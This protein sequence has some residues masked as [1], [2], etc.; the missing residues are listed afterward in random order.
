MAKGM[1]KWFNA[2]KGFGLIKADDGEE[3]VV[4]HK[5]IVGGKN[6]KEGER[7][8]FDVQKGARGSVAVNVKSRR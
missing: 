7:V 1:V 4:H 5:S 2:A 3:M 8:E 6:L